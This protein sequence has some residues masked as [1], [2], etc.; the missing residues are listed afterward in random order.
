MKKAKRQSTGAD[1]RRRQLRLLVRLCYP[2]I[3]ILALFLISAVRALAPPRA[4]AGP[5]PAHYGLP[6]KDVAFAAPGGPVL[7]GWLIIAPEAAATVVCLHGYPSDKS[8]ILPVV[9]FLY[10]HFN[11]LLFDFRA[12]GESAGRFTTLGGREKDDALAALD[13]L[14]RRAETAALPV[15]FW[16]YSLGGSVAIMAA[17]ESERVE[18]LAVDSAFASLPEMIAAYYRP[19]GPVGELLAVL[20]RPLARL[21]GLDKVRPE[22]VISRISSP[23][24][25]SHASGDPM[26]PADHARRLFRAAGENARL[27]LAE[28]DEHG[29]MASPG[30]REHVLSFYKANLRREAG[31]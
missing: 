5:G 20:S 21:I 4:R 23:I 30:Y 3:A 11:L 22:A 19:L 31:K 10:P 1:R 16:G 17:A 29:A 2:L 9:S 14:E 24:L 26:V 8:D 27:H 7:R 13:M 28:T 15:A 12:M 6:Y 18:A 25:I